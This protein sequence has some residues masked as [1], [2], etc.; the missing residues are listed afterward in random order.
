MGKFGLFPEDHVGSWNVTARVWQSRC[1]GR[2][3]RCS[4][5]REEVQVR[6]EG[7]MVIVFLPLTSCVSLKFGSICPLLTGGFVLI[8]KPSV[9]LYCRVG[10]RDMEMKETRLSWSPKELNIE[11]RYSQIDR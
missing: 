6:E 2:E 5:Q 11:R 8:R 7:A 9:S 10:I 1:G 4:D 3:G